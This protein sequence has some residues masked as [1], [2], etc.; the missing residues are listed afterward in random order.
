MLDLFCQ[1]LR[2]SGGEPSSRMDSISRR[3]MKTVVDDSN[4]ADDTSDSARNSGIRLVSKDNEVYAVMSAD[5]AGRVL[6]IT[7]NGAR[8][9]AR[10]GKLPARNTGRRWFFDAHAVIARSEGR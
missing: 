8:D 3:L 7:A 6:G 1:Y 9:L 2:K 4:S 10:R 5:E